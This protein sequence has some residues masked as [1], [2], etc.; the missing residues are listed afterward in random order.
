M[1]GAGIRLEGQCQNKRRAGGVDGERIRSEAGPRSLFAWRGSLPGSR[2]GVFMRKPYSRAIPPPPRQSLRSGPRRA[3]ALSTTTWVA[4]AARH[5]TRASP[6]HTDP[7]R[8]SNHR[9]QT[10]SLSQAPSLNKASI[11][12][13]SALR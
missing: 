13:T 5:T 2:T 3:P 8:E 9:A 4:C 7:R 10:C 11:Y 12:G 6:T 1:W